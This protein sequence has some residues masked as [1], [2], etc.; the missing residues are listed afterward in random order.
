MADISHT[1]YL[2]YKKEGRLAHRKLYAKS[3][4]HA[5]SRLLE[6]LLEE[7]VRPDDFQG[8]EV[9]GPE[10]ERYHLTFRGDRI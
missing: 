5:R 3:A 9:H 2:H 6:H 4:G 8:C 1:V 7:Q 10:N